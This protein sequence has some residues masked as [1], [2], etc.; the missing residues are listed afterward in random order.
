MPNFKDKVAKW[1]LEPDLDALRQADGKFYLLPGLHEKPW[2][3]YSLAVRT[4]IL[5]KLDLQVPKTW[6]ELYTVLKAM[7]AAYPDSY[8]LSDRWS[9]PTP[10]ATC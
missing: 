3:D 1:N 7:K 8:P 9:K 6:D 2:L 5:D 4:D 10:A